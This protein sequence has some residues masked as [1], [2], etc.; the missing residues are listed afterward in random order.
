MTQPG[1][2]ATINGILY[3]LLGVI[4][5]AAREALLRQRDCNEVRQLF[6]MFCSAKSDERWSILEALIELGDPYLLATREDPLWIGQILDG[7]EIAL[8]KHAEKRLEERRKE[9]QERAKRTDR[10]D[11]RAG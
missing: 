8:V 1:G 9:I 11:E 10:D 4:H 7:A 3:Q 5:R 6:T 2:S